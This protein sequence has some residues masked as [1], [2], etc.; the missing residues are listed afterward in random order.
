MTLILCGECGGS[1]STQ[2][3]VC[4]KCGMPSEPE[5]KEMPPSFTAKAVAAFTLYFVGWLPGFVANLVF[6]NEAERWKARTG[7]D[8]EGLRFMRFLLVVI[9]FLLPLGALFWWL[10][11]GRGMSPWR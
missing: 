8:P 10:I 7:R 3:K 6:W 9:G 2:A 4:P 1:L 5:P 11:L